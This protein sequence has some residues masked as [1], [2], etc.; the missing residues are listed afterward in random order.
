M[1]VVKNPFLNNRR[2]ILG[3]RKKPHVKSR[4]LILGN[5]KTQKGGLLPIAAALALLAPL[6]INGLAK[7]SGGGKKRNTKNIVIKRP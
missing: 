1:R 2:L 5:R 3:N 4:R 7:I 6:A